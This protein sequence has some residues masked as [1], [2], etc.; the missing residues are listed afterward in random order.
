[1]RRISI[2]ID[3]E[4]IKIRLSLRN[5]AMDGPIGGKVDATIWNELYW[6]VGLIWYTTKSLNE[7]KIAP[8]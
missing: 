5:E 7:K 3:N 2:P 4:I 8:K 6:K 1:M